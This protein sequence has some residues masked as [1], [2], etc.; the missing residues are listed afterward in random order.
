[1]VDRSQLP[2]LLK[3]IDDPSATTQTALAK[4]LAEFGPELPR[5][6]RDLDPPPTRD[7]RD[8]VR[9]LLTPIWRDTLVSNWLDY[10]TGE[11]DRDRLE[12][13]MCKISDFLTGLIFPDEP[14]GILLDKLADECDARTPSPTAR[15]L[16]R[17][18]FETCGLR[19]ATDDYHSPEHSA[20]AFAIHEKRGLPITLVAI[21][22]LVGKRLGLDIRG[23]N[24]PG[25]FLAIAYEDEP[26]LVDCFNGG[27]FLD[28]ETFDRQ[29]ERMPVSYSDILKLETDAEGMLRRV[30]RNLVNAYQQ[31][32]Q[33]DNRDAM[34]VLLRH[35]SR[36]QS[37]GVAGIQ[38]DA[39]GVSGELL[40]DAQQFP[41]SAPTVPSPGLVVGELPG[42]VAG[43]EPLHD[44]AAAGAAAVFG[45]GQIVQH[46]Q[47]GYRGVIVDYDAQC[48]ADEAWYWANQSHAPPRNQPWYHVLVHNSSVVIYAAESSLLPDISDEPVVHPLMPMFFIEK[49]PGHYVRNDRPWPKF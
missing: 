29:M 42:D 37:A 47:Y 9:R 40:P 46:K 43:E 48:E 27:Q 35:M 19:G 11:T 30:V 39:D 4:A 17:F 33:P 28:A 41:T 32:D 10:R 2:F 18:L 5:L 6:F 26:I 15:Q 49:A 22:M 12:I 34:V 25:M 16:A 14:V 7:R 36:T 1:M 21:F 24:F 23:C 8:A 44:M 20:L 38:I 45:V 3:L 13:G 31:A